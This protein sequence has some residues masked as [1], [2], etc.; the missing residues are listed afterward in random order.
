MWPASAS[1]ARVVSS[2]TERGLAPEPLGFD[3]AELD[4]G[5]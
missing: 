1:P 5:P 3:A 2:R 4:L